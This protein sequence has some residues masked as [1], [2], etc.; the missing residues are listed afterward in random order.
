[1]TLGFSTHIKGKP[2]YFVEK[3][4]IGI[5]DI[6]LEDLWIADSKYNLNVD[7]LEGLRPKFHTIRADPK[8]RWKV[9][10]NIHMVINNRTK[11]RFQFALVVKCKRV[12]EIEIIQSEYIND[13]KVKVDG[14]LLSLEDMQQLAWNDGFSSLVEFWMWFKEDFKGKIIHWTD[15]KY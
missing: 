15:L 3:I 13:C 6:T 11:D 8:D 1:M 14:R 5:K 2:T 4:L 10:N 7:V 9:G 12:Q